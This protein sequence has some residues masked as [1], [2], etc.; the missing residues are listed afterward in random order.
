VYADRLA[1]TTGE[2]QNVRNVI[3]EQTGNPAEGNGDQQRDIHHFHYSLKQL[4]LSAP[5]IM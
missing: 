2:R 3:N 4:A 5:A 1:E